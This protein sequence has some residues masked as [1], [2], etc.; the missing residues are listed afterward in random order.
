MEYRN[1]QQAF[2][3]LSVRNLEVTCFSLGFNLVIDSFF[4]TSCK[5][6]IVIKERYFAI[7][8]L[9]LEQACNYNL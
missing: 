6:N 1:L 7:V 8:I 2:H 5:G 4:Q 9:F 3:R